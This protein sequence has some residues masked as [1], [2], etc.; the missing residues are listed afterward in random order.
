MT[1]IDNLA[2]RKPLKLGTGNLT[3]VFG[4]NGSGKSGYVRILKNVCGKPLAG[5]LRVN[6]F[7]KELPARRRCGI[8]YSLG[9]KRTAVDWT[10]GAPVDGLRPIDIFD[11]DGGQLYLS[12]E[13]E[14]SYTPPPV[15]LLEQLATACDRVKEQLSA[16]IEALPRALP[17]MPAEFALTAAGKA[18][19]SLR[20]DQPEAALQQLFG[21]DRE[22]QQALESEDE[23]LRAADPSEVARQKQGRASLIDDAVAKLTQAHDSVSAV[24]CER[25][26]QLKGAA[27]KARAVAEEGA[28]ATSSAA[29]LAGIGSET[30]RALWEAARKYSATEAYKGSPFPHTD[31]AKCVLC[32]PAAGTRRAEAPPDVRGLRLRR[33]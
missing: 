24:E 30:W 12:K 29:D 14:S 16:E 4:K 18:Y 5:A 23:R 9:E 31:D 22:H 13:S 15:L 32:Q 17:E 10:P 21:W 7:A 28:R 6:V 1:G 33:D 3:V 2:P 25:I 20:A 11:T 8:E 27:I 26:E 19:S